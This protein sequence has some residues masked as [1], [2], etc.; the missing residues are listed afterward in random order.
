MALTLPVTTATVKRSFSD[1]K[2]MKTRLRNRPGEESLDQ[3]M[4]ISIEGPD[5]LNYD[6][7]KEIVTHWKVQKPRRLI[8]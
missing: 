7:L 2:L 4:H 8:I 1:M 6:E 5:T 3:T